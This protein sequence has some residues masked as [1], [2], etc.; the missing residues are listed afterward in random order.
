[1]KKILFNLIM[2]VPLTGF[3]QEGQKSFKED[4]FNHPLFPLLVAF[5]LFAMIV[6]LACVVIQPC[7]C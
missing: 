1:M 7:S 3:A 5:T 6:I 2:I 4:P